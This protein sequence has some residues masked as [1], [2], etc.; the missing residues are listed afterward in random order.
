MYVLEFRNL[1]LTISGNSKQ[2]KFESFV[3]GLNFEACVEVVKS[4]VSSFDDAINIAL[5]VDSA[6]WSAIGGSSGQ[7]SSSNDVPTPTEIENLGKGRQIGR[8]NS[9]AQ[10]I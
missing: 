1:V 8:G 4:T 9:D 10:F 5:R 2:E 6:I 7:V 3:S